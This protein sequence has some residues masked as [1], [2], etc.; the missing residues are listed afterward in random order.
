MARPNGREKGGTWEIH[1]G[2]VMRTAT[3][4]VLLAITASGCT[5]HSHGLTCKLALPDHGSCA[6]LRA[7]A[8]DQVA[9][10]APCDAGQ[11]E[12]KPPAEARPAPLPAIL[13]SL[14]PCPP[15][16]AQL[17]GPP[18]VAEVVCAE[19]CCGKTKPACLVGGVPENKHPAAGAQAEL[20][21]PAPSLRTVNSKQIRLNY[22]VTDVGPSGVSSV[23]LWYT[24]NGQPWAKYDGPAQHAPPYMFTA[25]EDGLYGFILVARNGIGLSRRAPRAGDLP[26][27]LIEVDQTKPVVELL[28]ARVEIGGDAPS[29]N[30]TWKATDKNL[31]RAPISLAYA[32]QAA[33]PWTPIASNVENA[34]NYL[35]RLPSN[36]PA[37]F[38]VRVEATDLAGNVG[39]SQMSQ[40]VVLDLALP[41]VSVL[42]VELGD[43]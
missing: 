23:E 18:K 39:M 3:I 15:A 21:G 30:L 13:D 37:R 43:K 38:L 29:L 19:T 8:P 40:P 7:P 11:A 41:S 31:G 26:Q 24:K 33:G 4:S 32:E 36:M 5:T 42:S 35:W 6:C 2:F 1:E 22:Q 27:V 20:G 25:G 16:P 12:A 34:G 10:A 17:P 28:D 14:P 9:N